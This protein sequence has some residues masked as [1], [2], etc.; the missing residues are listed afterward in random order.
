MPTPS[1]HVPRRTFLRGAS[2]ALAL[3]M[4]SRPGRES[5][6]MFAG[7][8]QVI[9]QVSGPKHLRFKS[10]DAA[11]TRASDLRGS[12]ADSSHLGASE[13][14]SIESSKFNLDRKPGLSSTM[15]KKSRE[16]TLKLTTVFETR[17]QNLLSQQRSP[18]KGLFD[19]SKLGSS[20]FDPSARLLEVANC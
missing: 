19:S 9:Q 18:K 6:K 3:P 10:L 12:H 7:L 14:N 17:K 1:W 16:A 2:A 15:T 11:S 4:L 5:A 20:P 8:E 13:L